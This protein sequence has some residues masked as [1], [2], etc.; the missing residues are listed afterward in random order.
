MSFNFRAFSIGLTLSVITISQ[1]FASGFRIPEISTIGT[2]TSNALIANTEELGALPY[3]PASMSFH[4]GKGIV[5]GATMVNYDAKVDPA[6]GT[7]TEMNSEE[8]FL[9]PNLFFMSRGTGNW[10]FGI[11]I[12]APFGL[13][14]N[15]PDNT[16]PNFGGLDDFETAHSKINMLNTNP[17]FA[18]KIDESS[19]FAIG[20]DFYDVRELV[21]NTQSVKISGDGQGYGFNLAYIKKWDNV[22]F[23]I[24]YRS[25]VKTDLKGTFDG[26][27]ATVIP[28]SARTAIG[29]TAELEFPDNWQMG[30]Y[31][32][33]TDDLGI[34]FDIERLGWS[35]FDVVNVVTSSGSTLNSSTNNWEDT[36]IFRLGFVYDLSPK[37][38][39]LFGY[40]SDETGQPDEYFSA[41]VP[42]A[43]R[44]LFGIGI[45]HDYD[46]WTLE[47]AYNYTDL[48]NR[49][50]NSAT[51]YVPGNEPNG[52]TAYNGTYSADVSLISIGFSKHF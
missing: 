33:A 9:I 30:V 1:A 36:T 42:D 52:S 49:T 38:K 21:F 45:T 12:N 44:Q 18:Y 47:A 6:G 14:T 23:G 31:W 39:L 5:V 51:A 41:R 40:A 43:D 26:S 19:S 8:N 7:P 17:N 10:S 16:F 27:A 4:D 34:E 48:K 29:V 20:F 13:E 32:Q 25:A 46:G 11:A 22:N 50:V 2:G 35:S 37:T 24:S 3:N 28:A 15:W